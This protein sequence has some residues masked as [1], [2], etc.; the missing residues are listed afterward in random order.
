MRKFKKALAL[1]L[2][3]ALTLV[4]LTACSDGEGGPSGTDLFLEKVNGLRTG[5]Y[6][7]TNLIVR[8]RVLDRRASAALSTT[9]QK[10]LDDTLTAADWSNYCKQEVNKGII[11]TDHGYARV[12]YVDVYK[13]P[14]IRYMNGNYDLSTFLKTSAKDKLGVLNADYVGIATTISDL[15]VHVVTVFAVAC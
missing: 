15:E 3:A 6:G 7:A 4:M 13:V 5:E 1:L 14:V 11:K 10:L 8:D 2:A 9:Y 12:V